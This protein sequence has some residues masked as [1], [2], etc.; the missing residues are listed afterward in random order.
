MIRTTSEVAGPSI[1]TAIKPI[2]GRSVGRLSQQIPNTEMASGILI[3]AP[4]NVVKKVGE[5]P[6][7]ARQETSDVTRQHD[8]QRGRR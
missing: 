3:E 2:N 8:R 4:P 5:L 7:P 6:V 1:S